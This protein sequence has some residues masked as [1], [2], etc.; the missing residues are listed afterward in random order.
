[1]G[2]DQPDGEVVVEDADLRRPQLGRNLQIQG[3]GRPDAEPAP[4]S[5]RT[6][7][8]DGSTLQ[9]AGMEHGQLA[10]KGDFADGRS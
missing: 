6:E 10:V 9:A 1:M 2:A 3:R 7:F 4:S 8:G 5:G